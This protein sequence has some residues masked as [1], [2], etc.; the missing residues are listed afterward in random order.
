MMSPGISVITVLRNA[1]VSGTEWIISETL[2][3]S[4]SSPFRVVRN[5]KAPSSQSSSS[6]T[7]CGPHGAKVS[8]AFPAV[9]WLGNGGV[10][11]LQRKRPEASAAATI[12]CHPVQQFVVSITCDGDRVSRRPRHHARLVDTDDRPRHAIPIHC[13]Q[14][15]VE[16][17]GSLSDSLD[18]TATV[19]QDRAIRSVDEL[20]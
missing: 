4:M 18:V 8:I 16:I 10:C 17:A 2:A 5:R 15:A 3:S 6:E 19:V 13:G 7:S 20:W 9:R 14:Q 1:T 12:G 11:V